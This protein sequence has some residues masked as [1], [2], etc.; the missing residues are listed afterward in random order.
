[1]LRFTINSKDK[2]GK[3]KSS[4]KKENLEEHILKKM[5]SL[6][7]KNFLNKNNSLDES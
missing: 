2:R 1:M 4:K 6:L 7:T 3:I 5:N